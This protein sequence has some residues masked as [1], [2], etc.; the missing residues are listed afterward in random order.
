MEKDTQ[1]HQNFIKT[2]ALTH[3]LCFLMACACIQYAIV[4]IQIALLCLP[5]KSIVMM[6]HYAIE[7]VHLHRDHPEMIKKHA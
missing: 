4:C 1:Y 7:Y 6:K 2:S 3:S 5:A